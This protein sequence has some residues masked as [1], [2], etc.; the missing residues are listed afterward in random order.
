MRVADARD[1]LGAGAEF[2]CHHRFGDHLR[3]MRSDDVDAENAVGLGVGENLHETGGLVLAQGAAVVRERH[4][5]GAVGH[6]FGL[7]LLL[8]LAHPGDF[9]RRIDNP[10][11]GVQV[12]PAGLAGDALGHHHALVH[13]LVREH[14]AAHHVADRIYVGQAGAAMLIHFDKAALVDFQADRRGAE[15]MRI[16]HA[17]DRHHQLVAVQRLLAFGGFVLHRHPAL[18]AAHLADVHA[19]LDLQPLL[20]DEHLPRLLRHRIIGCAKKTGQGFEDRDL[21]AQAPPHAAQF[22]ADH[23]RA[24][25]AELVRYGVES[26]RADVVADGLVVHFHAGQMARA[27]A[28]RDDHVVRLHNLGS[29]A[30]GD[31][32]HVFLGTARKLAVALEPGDLVLPE[33]HLD[34]AGELGYDLVLARL[35]FGDVYFRTGDGNTVV[36]ELVGHALVVFRRFEQGLRWN[37]AYVEAG[38]AEFGFALFVLPFVDHRGGKTELGA[39]YGGDVAGRAGAYDYDFERFQHGIYSGLGAFGAGCESAAARRGR[40]DSYSSSSRR[41][42]SSSASFIATSDSTASRPSMMRWS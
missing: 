36:A 15:I 38:A 16:G 8:G 34:A 10:G 28:G 18:A 25:N 32:D 37:A 7:Q 29:A 11:N 3:G 2:H 21:C 1:V 9:R 39:A 13:A 27:G 4:L 24:D 5:A 26:K 42:G 6:A 20:L 14:R 17:P 35:H 33:Q 22:Q 40:I 19:E 31:L 12:D 41:T 30:I 23:A